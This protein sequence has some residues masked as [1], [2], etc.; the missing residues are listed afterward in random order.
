MQRFSILINEEF[1]AS[2]SN[3]TSNL[4]LDQGYYVNTEKLD[5]NTIPKNLDKITSPFNVR[6]FLKDSNEKKTGKEKRQNHFNTKL[7]PLKALKNV[8]DNTPEEQT[9]SKRRRDLHKPCEGL[10]IRRY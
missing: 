8:G 3:T 6:T 2:T 1:S 9:E 10:Q 4:E 5:R 7:H